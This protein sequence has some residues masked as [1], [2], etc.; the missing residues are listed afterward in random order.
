MNTKKPPLERVI[1]KKTIEALR[2]RGGF[3][4]KV[5]GSPM[6]IAGIPDIIGC[7]RGRFVAFECKRDENGEPT[8]LQAYMMKKIREAGGVASLIWSAEQALARL[9]RIDEHRRPRSQSSG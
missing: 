7:Y 5:H 1:V 8:R 6:Q 2:A 4:F 9:D 3:W